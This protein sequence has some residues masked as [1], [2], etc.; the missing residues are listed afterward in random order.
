MIFG[1]CAVLLAYA[2]SYVAVLLLRLFIGLGEAAVMTS[3]LFTSLWYRRE[4]MAVRSGYIFAMT[5]IAGAITGLMSYGIQRD[6]EGAHGL[7]SWQWLFI[8]EGSATMAWAVVLWFF[9]P[10]IPE[11]ELGKKNS[12]FLKDDDE[13]RLIVMRSEAAQNV[14]H[15]DMK[16][17]QTWLAVKD[18]KVWLMALLFATHA[19]ALNGFSVFLPTFINEFGFSPL[20][21]QLYTIIPYAVAFI[22]MQIATYLSDRYVM[23]AVPMA[24]LSVVGMIGY[25]IIIAQTNP[26][27]GVFA[28]CLIVGA[29]YPGTIM[30]SGWLPSASA[31]YTKRAMAIWIS[32]IT[33]Q[34]FSIMV[35]QIYDQPPRFFKGYGIQLGLF[36]LSFL[37]IWLIRFMMKRSNDKKDKVAADFAARGETDPDAAKSLE[38]LC[39]DHPNFRYL[40]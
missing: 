26:A 9:L 25:I 29:V 27:V 6:L 23:R 21:T 32:Q 20:V 10:E 15:A 7:H 34:L 38:D 19:S 30:V 22:T 37:E 35:T 36:V 11:K 13:K 33:V 39:D 18:P 8:I 24:I 16:Y 3:F 1:M 17:S 28:S 5:P 31:G 4:E 2:R 14:M 40:Y 12:W